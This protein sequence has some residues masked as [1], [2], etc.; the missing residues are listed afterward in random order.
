MVSNVILARSLRRIL[1]SSQPIGIWELLAF[2][3]EATSFGLSHSHFGSNNLGILVT[4]LRRPRD[5]AGLQSMLGQN[6]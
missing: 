5:G 1:V 2:Q 6:V 3:I 4:D